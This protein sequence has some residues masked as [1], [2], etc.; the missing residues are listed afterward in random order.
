MQQ[1]CSGLN[2]RAGTS[3]PHTPAGIRVTESGWMD[4]NNSTNLVGGHYHIDLPFRSESPSLPNNIL[5]SNISR[6]SAGNLNWMLRTLHV[7]TRCCNMDMLKLYQQMS[8]RKVMDN[9][10]T[11]LIMEGII[12]QKA[13]WKLYWLWIITE[14]SASTETGSHKLSGWSLHQIRKRACCTDGRHWRH[15]SPSLRLWKKCQLSPFP[16][17]GSW[18]H[19]KTCRSGCRFIYLEQCLLPAAKNCWW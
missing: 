7:L 8:Y 15:V 2:S 12:P 19:F 14:Q 5:Q 16:V 1:G 17:V 10:S 4:V 9:C 18:W 13:S 3:T 6:V 11:F